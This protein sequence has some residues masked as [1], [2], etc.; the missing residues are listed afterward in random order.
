MA[1]CSKPR[2]RE[3]LL[4]SSHTESPLTIPYRISSHHPLQD[5][6][7][8]SHTESPPI[9]P[10]NLAPPSHIFC[11]PPSHIY[12]VCHHPIHSV[13]HHLIIPIEDI[14]TYPQHGSGRCV[15]HRTGS[16][17]PIYTQWDSWMLPVEG[18]KIYPRKY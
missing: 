9:I 17:P 7:S 5:L 16:Q 10:Y 15:G 4:L 3:Q 12:S 2:P 6:L 8:P 1:V 11:L 18:V 14:L 13:S